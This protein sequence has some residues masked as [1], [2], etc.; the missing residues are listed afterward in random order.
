M[1][2]ERRGLTAADRDNQPALQPR[3]AAA[4]QPT[5][6]FDGG[7]AAGYYGYSWAEV[8]SADAFSAFSTSVSA[9]VSW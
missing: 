4:A 9:G 3:L 6:V 5:H 8:L 2:G 7:Y 1:S